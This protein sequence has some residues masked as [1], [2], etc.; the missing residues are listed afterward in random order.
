MSIPAEAFH[1]WQCRK[2]AS[3]QWRVGSF[4]SS[5]P[6]WSLLSPVSNLGFVGC[7]VVKNPPANAG[8]TRDVGLIPGSGRSL[9]EGNG[10]P[11]QYSCLGNP[12]D[13]EAWW[14]IVHGIAKNQTRL[15]TSS[16]CI[17]CSTVSLS[18]LCDLV[19]ISI[20][21]CYLEVCRHWELVLLSLFKVKNG[22]LRNICI[23]KGYPIGKSVTVTLQ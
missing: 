10:N 2:P 18:L 11:L 21:I 20:K 15:S 4:S 19:A 23:K 7:T 5:L 6:F 14:A 12:T 13:R 9:G 22:R 17:Q 16:W 8:Y 3:H 1:T